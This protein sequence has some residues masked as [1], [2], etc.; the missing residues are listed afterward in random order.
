MKREYALMEQT[1]R[2]ILERLGLSY[3]VVEAD[4]GA[5]GGSGS[6]E[7]MVLADNGEDDIVVCEGCDYAANIEAARR[8]PKNVEEEVEM[9]PGSF[10]TPGVKTIE[11]LQDFFKVSAPFF[12]KAVAKKAI[13]P[14]HE[15]IV[16]F[17]L[18][19]SDTLQETKAAGACEAL[20]LEDVSE[21]ELAAAGLVAGFIGPD[22]ENV[23]VFVDKEL[24]NAEPMICGDNREDY[25]Y[26]GYSFK[27]KRF[28]YRDLVTVEAGDTCAK[29]GGTLRVTKGIEVGH[30]F[31][32][33]TRYSEAMGATFLD[34]NGKAQPF[35]MGTYG[36]G[37]SRLVA[38]VIEQHHD[39]KGCIW[40]DETTPFEIMIIISNMK[41][42]AQRQFGEKLY[43]DLKAAGKSVLLDDRNE[44]F[45]FK[46][47]DFELFGF[48]KAV[49]VGKGLKDGKVELVRREGLEKEPI[50]ADEIYDVLMEQR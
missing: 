37:V 44:R 3:R 49:I 10:H 7:F 21:E 50:L 32:L 39:D 11:A 4:S 38:V 2:R 33:G 46:I 42:E 6:R 30:I 12:V 41:D 25:H 15:E 23:R 17:F 29:C 40:T 18:R 5:I 43:E 16:L 47:S 26:V 35:V 27:D 9:T 24:E 19:G 34:R 8:A 20:E 1:Y 28:D 22:I 13:Y 36:I 45:G 48:P 14:D 31:Q